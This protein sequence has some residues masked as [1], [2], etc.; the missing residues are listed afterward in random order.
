MGQR[1]RKQAD[2]ETCL[3]GN[4]EIVVIRARHR[5]DHNRPEC[6][7]MDGITTI[8]CSICNMC[9]LQYIY[10][11]IIITIYKILHKILRTRHIY[12]HVYGCIHMNVNV[13]I[14]VCICI[15]IESTHF[16]VYTYLHVICTHVPGICVCVCDGGGVRRKTVMVASK[17]DDDRPCIYRYIRHA[18]VVRKEQAKE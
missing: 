4:L 1:R 8:L 14:Y 16:R 9:I 5:L 12:V 18:R 3:Y 7:C 13:C 15:Y 17:T 10:I 11:Y 2:W 6:K